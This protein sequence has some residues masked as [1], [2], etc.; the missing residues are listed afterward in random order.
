MLSRGEPLKR[1][2]GLRAGKGLKRGGKPLRRH[3]WL[4]SFNEARMEKRRE[5]QF[6]PKAEWIRTLPCGVCH[7]PELRTVTDERALAAIPPNVEVHH[8]VT[9]GAGGKADAIIPLCV[10]CHRALHLVGRHTFARE[11]K[12]SLADLRDSYEA[13]WKCL[14]RDGSL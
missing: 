8:V 10:A 11:H 2:K 14:Q 5:K 9:R 12:V 3:K 6:G 1:G 4:R 7:G 13:L